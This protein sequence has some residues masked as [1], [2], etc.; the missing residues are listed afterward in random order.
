[1]DEQE[2]TQP[3]ENLERVESTERAEEQ[4]LQDAAHEPGARL[5]ETQSF[6]QAEGIEEALDLA[7]E[8][9]PSPEERGGVLPVPIPEPVFE[10]QPESGSDP[11]HEPVEATEPGPSPYPRVAETDA[12]LVPEMGE[13]SLPGRAAEAMIAPE[14]EFF[15]GEMLDGA[16]A[17][18]PIAEG[19]SDQPGEPR[20]EGEGDA[21]RPDDIP[22]WYLHEDENGNVTVVDENGKPVDSPP[23]IVYFNGKYYAVYPG[24]DI[25]VNEDG[26]VDDPG[27]LAKYEILAYK[28]ST[29]GMKVYYDEDGN[30]KVVD[31]TGKPVASPPAIVQD[32]ATGKYYFVT[33]TDP[34][35][36]ASFAKSG[37]FA[38][39]LSQGLITEASEYKPSTEGMKV[40][41]DEDGNPK[42][43]DENGK[44]VASPPAIVQD[45][46]TGKYYFITETDPSKLASFSKSGN[47]A[48]ALSQ[49][50][51]T[52]APEYK[53]STAGMK[54]YYDEDGNP[55]VV[56]EN[57]KP[58]ASPPAIVQDPATGKYYFITETDPSKLASF[59]KS[60]NF[61]EALSQGL[62]TEASEYKPSTEGMKV[63]FDEDG[64]PKVVDENGKPVASPPAIVQ[65]P[66]TGK[67][68][69]VKEGYLK[70][71]WGEDVGHWELDPATGK[72]Y[73]VAET[74]PSRLDPFAKSGNFAEALSKG[75]IT[76]APEYKP[77]TEGMKVYANKDGSVS[78]VDENGKPVDS[79][80][81][82]IKD[83]STGK[84]YFVTETDPA[85]LSNLAKGDFAGAL[86][87]GLI[88]EASYYKPPW[89][90]KKT[91]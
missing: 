42:V 2:I 7:L 82:L 70:H 47:F 85:K 90:G 25:P 24:D 12:E 84:Y 59:S 22:K 5:E 73:F 86:A 54:V 30:P 40:Y 38:E 62:I 28:P 3:D 17:V 15:V 26:T 80:P 16:I 57:G 50:L 23:N 69:F 44:L 88:V 10:G 32:P 4:A 1:M 14:G 49:G 11:Y 76:E 68:Y 67:Y 31:E 20:Q 41:Y 89:W 79:P 29:A 66:A 48:E 78:V 91:S 27:K 8:P 51:I 74:D 81:A 52:E 87:Q 6:E 58:V 83:E 21:E 55:K 63:Y 39:A 61:A 37:N 34:S 75:L 65:D 18:M 71:P 36:L 64:N 43:V 56:D 72:Y 13:T 77:S 45:P 33:E 19:I 35:K 9:A 53:P 46:A 60:G